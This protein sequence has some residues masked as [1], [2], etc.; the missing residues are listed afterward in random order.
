MAL[1]PVETVQNPAFGAV[2]L[3][4]FGLGYQRESIDRLPNFELF[5]L[6]LPII[7]HAKSL[8][9]VTSTL[10]GSGLGKFVEK[11]GDSRE[12]LVAIHDR[13]LAMRLLTLQSIGIGVTTRLLSLNY[14]TASVRA[15]DAKAPKSP[16]RTKRH[17]AGAEKLG[18]WFARVPIGQTFS[19]LQVHP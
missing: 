3:W 8:A 10:A 14:E 12:D 19:T 4:Q 16:E 11:L 7:L 9:H 13:A 1:S 6:V 2:L 5:F 15:N 17:L 18:T